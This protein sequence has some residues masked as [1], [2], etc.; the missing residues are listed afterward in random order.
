LL[1]PNTRL[2]LRMAWRMLEILLFFAGAA[3]LLLSAVVVSQIS[4]M[5]F[6]TSIPALA[7]YILSMFAVLAWVSARRDIADEDRRNET[8]LDRLRRDQ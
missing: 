8:I 4:I 5:L 3:L 6:G 2:L 7:L 1:T